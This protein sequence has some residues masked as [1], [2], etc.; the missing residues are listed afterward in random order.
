MEEVRKRRRK[1]VKNAYDK[2]NEK[3]EDLDGVWRDVLGEPERFGFWIVWGAEKHGKSWLN[4]M[5]ANMLREHA[6]VLYISAEEGFSEHFKNTMRRL[7]IVHN[8]GSLYLEDEKLT[9]KEIEEEFEYKNKEGK[10]VQRRNPIEIVIVDNLLVYSDIMKTAAVN[11]L[12]EKWAKRKLFIFVAHEED[13]EVV[14]AAAKQVKRLATVF[15]RVEGLSV[16]V[17]GRVA[18]GSIV[19]NEEKASL[20]HGHQIL[21]SN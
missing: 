4:L 16:N 14:G 9:V 12:Y 21:E 2:S 8:C 6:R 1:T 5:L 3:F 19:I 20:Y 11:K 7:D 17:T 10:I 18:G 13:G 15:F